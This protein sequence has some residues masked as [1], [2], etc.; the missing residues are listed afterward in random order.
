VSDL[1]LDVSKINLLKP[2]IVVS[3]CARSLSEDIRSLELTS[4]RAYIATKRLKSTRR[5]GFSSVSQCN[6]SEVKHDK[7]SGSVSRAYPPCFKK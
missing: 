4:N 2:R 3:C 7:L 5:A 6:G 1:E